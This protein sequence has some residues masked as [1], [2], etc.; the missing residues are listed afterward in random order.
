MS[1]LS[2]IR[3]S[4]PSAVESS[5][6]SMDGGRGMHLVFSRCRDKCFFLYYSMQAGQRVKS[7]S[8][9]RFTPT[10]VKELQDMGNQV[11]P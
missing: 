11:R 1:S 4:A 2:S 3:S 8:M 10:E 9:A 7:I 5:K 6:C